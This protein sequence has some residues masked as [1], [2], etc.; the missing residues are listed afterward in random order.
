MKLYLARMV[1]F[2]ATSMPARSSL[3]S[4]SV[5]PRALASVTMS[6]KG[7]SWLNMLKMYDRVPL[8]MPSTLRMRS[9][10]STKC[11]RVAITGRPAPTVAC[12]HTGQ[13]YRL[14]QHALPAY[15]DQLIGL[16]ESRHGQATPETEGQSMAEKTPA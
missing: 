15:E 9:P 3:G 2:L 12:T 11:F 6:E 5:Y 4:G 8:K 16:L 7:L 14:R 10:V 1:T 13:R